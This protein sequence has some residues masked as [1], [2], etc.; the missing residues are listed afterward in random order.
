MEAI[1]FFIAGHLCWRV[2][3]RPLF[4]VLSSS[5]Y[6]SRTAGWHLPRN[7][8]PAPASAPLHRLSASGRFCSCSEGLGCLSSPGSWAASHFMS[9]AVEC[10]GRD[11]GRWPPRLESFVLRSLYGCVRLNDWLKSVFV[12]CLGSKWEGS[13]PRGYITLQRSASLNIT[14]SREAQPALSG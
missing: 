12:P 1:S 4:L 6:A 14:Q 9:S 7:V 11:P 8:Q 10:S 3:K 5:E 2:P 13:R